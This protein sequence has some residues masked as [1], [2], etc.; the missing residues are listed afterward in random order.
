[1]RIDGFK[2][3]RG[4]LK[5]MTKVIY[6]LWKDDKKHLIIVPDG[7]QLDDIDRRN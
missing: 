4:M 2:R 3:T 1:M 7:L 6:R 5:L